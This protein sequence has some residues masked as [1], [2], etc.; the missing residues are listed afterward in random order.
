MESYISGIANSGIMGIL[1]S[2]VVLFVFI[3]AFV[4]LRKAWRRGI[5]LGMDKRKLKKVATNSAIFSILPSLPILIFLLLLM[6]YLG[7]FFPWLRL[8]VIGSGAYENIVANMTAQSFGLTSL[9]EGMDARI[10]LGILW[11]MT[12]GILW[13][14]ILTLFG[15]K[16]VQKGLVLLKGKNAKISNTVLTCLMIALYC[17]FAVP[18]VTAFK[19]VQSLGISAF[20]PLGTL[21]VGGLSTLLFNKI[22]HA[23]KKS[24]F[25][26]FSFPLSLV[27]GMAFAI[28]ISIIL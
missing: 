12:L 26:E 4:F 7:K 22:A 18:Y 11:A 19:N 2:M 13:E 28:V 15:S 9:S 1:C 20:I 16:F 6:P 10:F 23:T 5:E 14:P 21:V 17:I 24:V 27:T 3:Q 8:S 25:K